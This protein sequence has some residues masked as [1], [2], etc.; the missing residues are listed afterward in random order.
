[1]IKL[2][3]NGLT[4][5]SITTGSITLGDTTVSN[6][7]QFVVKNENGEIEETL[8][9]KG[10]IKPAADR[11]QKFIDLGY[12]YDSRTGAL[13]ALRGVDYEAA[14]GSFVLVARDAEH[15]FTLQGN[16]DGILTWAGSN[17]VTDSHFSNFKQCIAVDATRNEFWIGYKQVDNGSRLFLFNNN[18]ENQPGH[19]QLVTGTNSE[20]ARFSILGKPDGTLSWNTFTFSASATS[21]CSYLR[22]SASDFM[23][24]ASG[25]ESARLNLRGENNGGDFSLV[26]KNSNTTKSLSGYTDGTLTWNGSNVVTYYLLNNLSTNIIWTA[27]NSRTAGTVGFDLSNGA[28]LACYSKNHTSYTGYFQLTASDG[29]TNKS[30]VGKPDG[31]LAWDNQSIVTNYSKTH[32]YFDH[33]IAT[34]RDIGF[35]TGNNNTKRG[36]YMAF[37]AGGDSSYPGHFSI[38]AR[39]ANTATT[40]AGT[41]GG[42][43][44]WG[45]KIITTHLSSTD[46]NPIFTPG[47]IIGMLADTTPKGGWLICQGQEV[48]RTTYANLFAAIGTTYGAGNGSTTFNLPQT[49]NRVLMGSWSSEFSKERAAGLPNITGSFHTRAGSTTSGTSG[50]IYGGYGVIKYTR[51]GTGSTSNNATIA[52]GAA[53]TVSGDLVDFDA[54]RASSIYGNSSTVQPPALMMRWYIKY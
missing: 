10:H 35:S 9:L 37:K 2:D 26:A 49:T 53:S 28:L 44:T 41:P 27:N 20:G 47:C 50:A 40:L 34:S 3:K 23:I 48:S 36:A 30:L 39:D 21:D 32:I 38:T 14:P 31:S 54:S 45:G 18:D 1:M 46:Y 15:N 4:A 11:E 19:F 6:F 25:K 8:Y 43:L 29:S 16:T 12:D 17:V 52:L 42:S 13:M 33:T 51:N 22:F 5:P 24:Q 7:N